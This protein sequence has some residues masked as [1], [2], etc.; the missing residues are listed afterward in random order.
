MGMVLTA[1]LLF[2]V[3]LARA[4]RLWRS[5]NVISAVPPDLVDKIAAM[6]RGIDSIAVEVERIG[7]G[8]RFVTQLLAERADAA[9][10][11]LPR[12]DRE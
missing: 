6:E 10:V 8:Q 5:A 9:R 4:R 2:P 11:A 7:E 12:N 1:A 3:M